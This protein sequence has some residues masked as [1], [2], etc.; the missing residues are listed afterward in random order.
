VSDALLARRSLAL[1]DE[2]LDVPEEQWES[3]IQQR[4][5]SDEPLARELRAL[6]AAAGRGKGVLE[7]P[8]QP[9][10]PAA[11]RDAVHTALEDRYEIAQELGRGGM[12]TVFRARAN[13][14]TI[15]MSSSRCW[16]PTRCST[17]A[18]NAF[19]RKYGLLRHSRIRTSCRSSTR[20]KAHGFLYYVM[21]FMDGESLRARL[22]RS[23]IGSQEAVRVLRDVAGALAFAHESGVVHRDIKPENVFL[24]AGH[25]YLLDFGIA[26][27]VDDSYNTN[28]TQPGLAI[29]TR[30]YM[31]PE[32]AAA[33]DS[34]DARADIYAWGLLGIELLTGEII[35]AHNS[36]Q[37]AP[38]ALSRIVELPPSVAS[39]LLE[40][41]AE[42]P[43]RR[44]TSM[45]VIVQQLDSIVPSLPLV[46]RKRSGNRRV[47][48]GYAI[49]G[50]AALLI[51]GV[52]LRNQ[53]AGVSEEDAPIAVSVF[54]NETGDSAQSVVG[55]FAGDW[56]S[57]GL[58]R[59]E[60]VRVVPW[61]ESRAASENAI[62]KG[63]PLIPTVRNE[64]G[65][66]MVVTGTYYRRRDSLYLS[67]QLVNAKS[68]MV[69]SPVKEI[70]FPVSSPEQGIT[71]LR[72]R[73]MGAVA[74]MR[75]ERVATIP[76]LSRNPPSFPC[77]SVVR[78]GARPLSCAG[79]RGIATDLPRCVRTRYDVYAGA[80]A[81]CTRGVQRCQSRRSGVTGRAGA[82][83]RERHECVSE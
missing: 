15:A 70:V 67:A 46:S 64:T 23:R 21:P 55:R 20:V 18:P 17:S 80:P 14:S 44:P 66:G 24:T 75:T 83:T 1:L 10:S 56:V 43:D 33:A 77:V 49:A 52:A 54:R 27:L 31:A 35:A 2:L 5:G 81:W 22:R 47:R 9:V 3:W 53:F 38:A 65:A 19:C 45:R 36:D 39:L 74:A 12:S 7:M 57:Q 34:I 4:T 82:R 40:C 59:M 72:D 28:I 58:Q 41:V 60:V 26:K 11:L 29:G 51:G 71:E 63:T 30:R 78:S 79:I 8:Q 61:S 50:V 69:V 25:A 76:G 37:H 16:I 6:V 48:T 73:V 13:A 42:E 62:R 68:G 32:Q